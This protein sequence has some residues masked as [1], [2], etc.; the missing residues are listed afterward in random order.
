MA[1]AQK[2]IRRLGCIL[3]A[4]LL[5][6]SAFTTLTLTGCSGI[7]K[8]RMIRYLE[9][10]YGLAAEDIV[11]SGF[12]PVQLMQDYHLMYAYIKGGDKY[13]DEFT[14][15][16]SADWKKIEDN[17]YGLLIREELE[18]MAKDVF[19]DVSSGVKVKAYIKFSDYFPPEVKTDTSLQEVLANDWLAGNSL[20]VYVQEGD[21]AQGTTFKTTANNFYDEWRKVDP[22]TYSSQRIMLITENIYEQLCRNNRMELVFDKEPKSFLQDEYF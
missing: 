15:K 2:H 7:A 6:A 1:K 14:V 10:K 11:V 21:I 12:T 13:Q 8:D 16:M 20:Y 9:N 17:Y 4:T 22:K 18:Q 19:A 3:L 5:I